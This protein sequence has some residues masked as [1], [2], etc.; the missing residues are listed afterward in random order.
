MN[1][2]KLKQLVRWI[3]AHGFDVLF[4]ACVALTVWAVNQA[5]TGPEEMQANFFAVAIVCGGVGGL[6]FVGDRPAPE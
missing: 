1:R 4:Y 3:S 6:L 2:S 5:L